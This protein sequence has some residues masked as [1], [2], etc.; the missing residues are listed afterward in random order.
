MN[1][2]TDK[3]AVIIG[4][5][6]PIP[7]AYLNIYEPGDVWVKTQGCEVCP[8]ESRAKCC[9]NCGM[10]SENQG[11]AWHL[12]KNQATTHKPWN[13]I[14]KPYPDAAMSFCS[15]EFRCTQGSH[16]GQLRRVQDREG[17]FQ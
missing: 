4:L 16:E 5:D 17:I 9:N 13:C 12:E 11:C 10:F 3:R 7:I 8:K 15:L 14:V 1:G 6:R 2:V